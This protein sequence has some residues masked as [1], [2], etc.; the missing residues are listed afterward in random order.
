MTDIININEDDILNNYNEIIKNK[1][2]FIENDLIDLINGYIFYIEDNNFI[3][4]KKLELD[5][6]QVGDKITISLSKEQKEKI[7][8]ADILH[9]KK[10]S[11]TNMKE[12]NASDSDY[13]NSDIDYLSESDDGNEMS[14]K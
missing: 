10:K 7:S 6:L 3:N 2:Y 8:A 13:F 4:Y 1:D 5:K 9:A 14:Y 11:L 12:D